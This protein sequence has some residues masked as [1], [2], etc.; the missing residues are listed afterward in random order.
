VLV[1][2]PKQIANNPKRPRDTAQINKMLPI[3]V[4]SDL[5]FTAYA[6]RA[7][8]IPKVILAATITVPF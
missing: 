5:V 3:M 7:K 8:V 4:K 6:V 1:R 2:N